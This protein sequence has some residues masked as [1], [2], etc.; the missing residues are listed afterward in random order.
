MTW[1]APAAPRTCPVC[2][3]GNFTFRPVLWPELIAA[4]ELTPDE[5]GLIDAQQGLTCLAC[6]GNLRSL[7]LA[8]ALLSELGAAGPL[9][10]Y[11]AS[12]HAEARLLE[13]NEAGSLS[14]YLRRFRGYAF[15]GYPE[16]DLQALPF[17]DGRF[18]LVVHSDT[19]EHVS[20]PVSGLRECRRVLAPGGR[21]LA[22]VPMVPSR[23]TRRRI[24]LPP[25]YH[26]S[27]V[28]RSEDLR[29]VTE[30]GA[31][32]FLDWIAAGWTEVALYTLGTA[33][34][35]ALIGRKPPE[36]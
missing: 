22:T 4:W 28:V 14:P 26:G 34:S 27:S 35:F 5:T 33:A 29:V 7:T 31:D 25:S 23:L 19:L 30:Y 17:P 18:E 20:D 10:A 3:G 16:A 8:A 15:A 6:G 21:L 2:G 1:T 12:G 11:T 24:G 9:D 36:P 13:V 32:F